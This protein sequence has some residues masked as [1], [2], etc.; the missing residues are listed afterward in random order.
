MNQLPN[1]LTLA[2]LMLAPIVAFALWR[3]YTL[4]AEA[5]PEGYGAAVD[6]AH[7][8]ALAA[9]LLFAV[10]ALTDLF[11]GMAARALDAHSKFGRVLDPIADKA[12]V[13]LPLLVI[14]V[15]AWRQG[16]AGWPVIAA[17]TGVIVL[18]DVG[19]SLLR[20]K[21]KD[22][23]GVRVSGLAKWKTA[24]EMAAVGAP[25]LMAAAPALMAGFA[26]GP[27][28]VTGWLVVLGIAAALSA[29]TALQYLTAKAE[30]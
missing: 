28:L 5:A 30:G 21:A 10:A 27:E 12:L 11:D 26:P 15:A 20:L 13:G 4:P 23:E 17:A 14:S 2:R 24:L 7:G 18:R 29:F 6:A 9:A 16:W 19:I 3:A 25:I 22:G 8:W 1:A